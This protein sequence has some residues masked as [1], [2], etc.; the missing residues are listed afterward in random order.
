M[1]RPRNAS[2][3]VT[4]GE[5]ALVAIALGIHVVT[6]PVISHRPC[7]AI[8]RNIAHAYEST[9]PVEVATKRVHVP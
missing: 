3:P 5:G 6:L 1:G 2:T 9:I 8:R 7:P 4:R